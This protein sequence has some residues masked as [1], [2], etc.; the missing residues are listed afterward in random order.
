MS[1]DSIR[2][3]FVVG[4][5]PS[6]PPLNSSNDLKDGNKDNSNHSKDDIDHSQKLKNDNGN[7]HQNG[8]YQNEPQKS[9]N[10]TDTNGKGK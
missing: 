8:T 7:D 1:V 2:N 10:L 6:Q 5:R 3:E 4:S 9:P